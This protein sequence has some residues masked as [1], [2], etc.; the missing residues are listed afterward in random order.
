VPASLNDENPSTAAF[1]TPLA[2][3]SGK[4]CDFATAFQDMTL[5]INTS[6]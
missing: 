6:M 1:P 4:G 3:F 2:A 5:I